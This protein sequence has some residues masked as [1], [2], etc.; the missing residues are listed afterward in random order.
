M[1]VA[2]QAVNFRNNQFRLLPLAGLQGVGE[3]G[4]VIGPFLDVR[5]RGQSGRNLGC[6][7]RSPPR[8]GRRFIMAELQSLGLFEFLP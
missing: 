8:L 7:Q 2:G 1:D 3:L 6:G 4:P 5:F